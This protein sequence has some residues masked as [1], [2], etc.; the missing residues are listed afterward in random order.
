MAMITQEQTG[1]VSRETLRLELMIIGRSSSPVNRRCSQDAM[2]FGMSTVCVFMRVSVRS[3]I[4]GRQQAGVRAR[5]LIAIPGDDLEGMSRPLHV[6]R[7]HGRN[8]E[9]GQD[10]PHRPSAAS[11]HAARDSL[12]RLRC[13]NSNREP[14]GYEPGALPLRHIAA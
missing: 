3:I 5:Q 13:P 6:S 9:T 8:A 7:G 11:H 12:G 2:N 4:R 1:D 10:C 14:P